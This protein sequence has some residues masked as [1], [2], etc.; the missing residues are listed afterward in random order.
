MTKEEHITYWHESALHDLESA[1]SMFESK[2]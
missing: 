1:E 2:K